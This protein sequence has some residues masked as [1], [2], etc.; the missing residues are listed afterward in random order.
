MKD[1]LQ[2]IK[3][4]ID[5]QTDA[6]IQ[7]LERKAELDKQASKLE[8]EHLQLKRDFYL[9]NS[10]EQLKALGTAN[11][12]DAARRKEMEQHYIN[13]EN[14]NNELININSLVSQVKAR[15]SQLKAEKDILLHLDNN[16]TAKK[17]V[18][19]KTKTKEASQENAA[20]EVE[21]KADS[22][23]VNEIP[24]P[25]E[26]KT[27]E[28][29]M[30]GDGGVSEEIPELP[31]K[32][33]DEVKELA[34][35]GGM[36]EEHIDQII[37]EHEDI[38]EETIQTSEGIFNEFECKSPEKEAKSELLEKLTKND[39]PQEEIKSHEIE[40]D[41]SS[42]LDLEHDKLRPESMNLELR[43]LF[44]DNIQK[45]GIEDK[46]ISKFLEFIKLDLKEISR[47]CRY[48]RDGEKVDHF[49]HLFKVKRMQEKSKIQTASVNPEISKLDEMLAKD[50]ELLARH[51][52][53]PLSPQAQFA[54]EAASSILN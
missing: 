37:E 33:Q 16:T 18:K 15:L 44:I 41:V 40:F 22:G 49:I 10:P 32:P 53:K 4:E 9:K 20:Q 8:L 26:I 1:R 14:N 54:H 39:T 36:E 13:A 35:T 42:P 29:E 45:K 24:Q 7:L 46:D 48:L 17:T 5:I 47:I 3:D 6:I 52:K 38:P 51:T 12:Q 30:T 31:S 21:I 11:H 43:E 28:Q 2:E 50:E 34:I 25:E 23:M 19:S 27:E